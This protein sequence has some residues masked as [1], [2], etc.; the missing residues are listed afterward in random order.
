MRTNCGRLFSFAMQFSP[1]GTPACHTLFGY[2]ADSDRRAQ[3]AG[4]RLLLCW[5]NMRSG[6]KLH[7]RFR[8]VLCARSRRQQRPGLSDAGMLLFRPL[9]LPV[10][11]AG[12]P[13]FAGAILATGDPHATRHTPG[14]S[15]AAGVACRVETARL[16]SLSIPF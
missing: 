14:F 5:W 15:A 13:G 6:R 9:L 1:H 2:A 11:R 8:R 7:A 12:A 10:S 16:F 3:G 4:W